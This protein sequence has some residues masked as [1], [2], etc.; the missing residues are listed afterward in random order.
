MNPLIILGVLAGLP[1]LLAL[2]LRVNGFLLFFSIMAGDLLVRFL[3]DDATLV[4]GAF[5]KGE[6]ASVYAQLLLFFLPVVIT[7]L[8]VRKS[9]QK[10]KIFINI[11]SQLLSGLVIAAL[12]I[13]LLSN[14]MILQL[15]STPIGRLLQDMR[16]NIIGAAV[17]LNLAIVWV[18]FRPKHD[19]KHKKHH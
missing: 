6:A 19:S 10:S 12:A 18:A 5:V 4:I 15:T 3:G 13:P 1:V 9:V 7:L 8:L 17:L 14:S 11:P 16:D 2:F